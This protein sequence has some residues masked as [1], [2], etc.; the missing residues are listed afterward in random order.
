VLDGEPVTGPHRTDEAGRVE[1]DEV[2][3]GPLLAER[4]VDVVHDPDAR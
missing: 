3:A 1:P 4:L 2:K